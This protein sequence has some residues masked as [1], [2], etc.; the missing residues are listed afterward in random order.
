MREP[1]G[2]HRLGSD[3]SLQLS[4]VAHLATVAGQGDLAPLATGAG[5]GVLGGL[6]FLAGQ[7][8]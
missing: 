2:L 5:Q 7:G 6:P 8:G 4:L 1:V 3:S